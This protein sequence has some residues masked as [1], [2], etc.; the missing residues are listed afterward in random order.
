MFDNMIK[1]DESARENFKI[2]NFL[3]VYNRGEEIVA[4]GMSG[5]I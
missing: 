3:V 5:S 1:N 4:A 2:S